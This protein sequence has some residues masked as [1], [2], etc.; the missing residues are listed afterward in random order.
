[1]GV[2][3]GAANAP[4]GASGGA[5]SIG[6]PPLA[7]WTHW[8]VRSQIVV[9]LEQPANT[10]HAASAVVVLILVARALTRGS[11]DRAPHRAIVHAWAPQKSGPALHM[12]RSSS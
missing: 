3:V 6:T 5:S 9:A 2:R 12:R 11:I 4:P 10:A 7:I 1:A 8:P